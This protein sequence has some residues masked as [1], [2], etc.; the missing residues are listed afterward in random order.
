MS[1]NVRDTEPAFRAASSYS[2]VGVD[3]AARGALDNSYYTTNLQN[4]VLLKSDRELTQDDDTL[5][6]LVQYRDDA[7]RWSKDFGKAM[8]RLSDLR[9]PM[10]SRSR[11]EIR[12]NCRLTN[13]SPGR[14]VV[15]ALKRFLQ[16]RYNHRCLVC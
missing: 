2:G 16:R 9:P 14:A 7:D 3:T 4:M 13:L 6:R 8:E 11:L 5:A 15:H 12:K 1:N 10:G